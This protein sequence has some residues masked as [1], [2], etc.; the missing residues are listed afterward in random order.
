MSA[1]LIQR[2]RV[3]LGWGLLLAI[4]LDTAVQLCW[5]A[6]VPVHAGLW[7]TLPLTLVQPLFL[8][9]LLLHVWQL[10]N[11]M[12]VL[13][14]AE[15]SFVQPI[16]A[17]SYV[18]VAASSAWLFGESVHPGTIAGILLVL[19]GVGLVGGS[20]P[21]EAAAPV[22]PD[23]GAG[24]AVPAP[25]RSLSSDTL[26]IRP[27]SA[28]HRQLGAVKLIG[29][30]PPPRS[31]RR[32]LLAA[33]AAG[34][35]ILVVLGAVAVAVALISAGNALFMGGIVAVLVAVGLETV[36]QVTMKIGTHG[37]PRGLGAILRRIASNSWIWVAISAFVLE[38]VFWTWAL[39][40][41]PL[42]VAFPMGSTCF[43]TVAVCSALLLRERISPPRW[44]G[45]AL[46][47]G[48]VVLIGGNGHPL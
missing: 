25:C 38:A 20:A 45:I 13:A 26:A 6:S 48:G 29:A 12:M 43:V 11:W 35:G 24:G 44:L 9:S 2:R 8:L 22:L 4:A 5:K 41:L 23:T 1:G 37:M 32:K 40:V 30:S 15:L 42:V 7:R 47:I 14:L 34:A 31:R 36:G 16:T 33:A 28:G 10:F 3:L 21:A 19:L 46:I 17:L 18:T 39:R 27:G